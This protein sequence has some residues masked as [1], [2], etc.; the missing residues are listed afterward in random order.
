MQENTIKLSFSC[1]FF[2]KPISLQNQ[3]LHLFQSR[4]SN[5]LSPNHPLIQLSKFID[6]DSLEKEF[7]NLFVEQIGQPAKPVRLVVGIMM[8][9]HMY[10]I[11][12]ENIV[13]R[14]IENAYWQYFC[15]YEYIQHKRPIHPTSLV[16]WR[17]RLGEEGMTKILSGTIVAA[18][19]VGVVKKK[20]LKKPLW[21]PQ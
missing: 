8:L 21:T 11:S 5:L 19:S 3:Q 6:W 16:R 7:E 2:M 10:G 14:W 18:V 15:G 9:Q 12:D 1:E 17:R 20:A 13:Y 4:L